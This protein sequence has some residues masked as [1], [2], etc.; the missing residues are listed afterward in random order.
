[1]KGLLFDQKQN[2]GTRFIF[3][4][5]FMQVG[6]ENQIQNFPP[7]K[8]HINVVKLHITDLVPK[9]MYTEYIYHTLYIYIFII[10]ACF[11]KFVQILVTIFS[12]VW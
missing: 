6:V 9:L 3:V 1:M 5:T 11:L 8:I 7:V 4:F 10:I 2:L 12:S